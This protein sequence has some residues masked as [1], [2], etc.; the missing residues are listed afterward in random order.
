M[1]THFVDTQKI[2]ISFDLSLEENVETSTE[3]PSQKL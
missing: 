2:G 3:T 1:L